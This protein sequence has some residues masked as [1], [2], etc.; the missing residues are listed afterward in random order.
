MSVL[1][2]GA[3]IDLSEDYVLQ[4]DFTLTSKDYYFNFTADNVTFDGNG[5]T[6]TLD[7]I[8]LY[9][10]L[11]YNRS[12]SYTTIKNLNLDIRTDGLLGKKTIE[13]RN[14]FM[15]KNYYGKYVEFRTS[16][17]YLMII[18]YFF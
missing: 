6:I 4:D 16:K 8:E 9:D 5:K 11:F 1:F 15:C 17:K 18:T 13:V 7:N 2:D 14:G 10:G 3:N 12:F